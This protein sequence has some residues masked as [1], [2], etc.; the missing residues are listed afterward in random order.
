MIGNRKILNTLILACIASL[1]LMASVHAQSTISKIWLGVDNN[2]R[3]NAPDESLRKMLVDAKL[4]AVV[5]TSGGMIMAYL[6][7]DGNEAQ[8]T[9]KMTTRGEILGTKV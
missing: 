6:L 8:V 7:A 4:R 2:L 1:M 9:V 3:A 5:P